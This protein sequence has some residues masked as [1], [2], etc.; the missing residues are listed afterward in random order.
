MLVLV[1]VCFCFLVV[2]R[3][4]KQYTSYYASKW[5][6]RVEATRRLRHLLLLSTPRK[7]EE[8]RPGMLLCMR[9]IAY[10]AVI[11]ADRKRL[12]IQ[13]FAIRRNYG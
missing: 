1:L 2:D 9:R 7:N 4:K 3:Q 5:V 11:R 12:E 6:Q 10:L 13:V 8:E